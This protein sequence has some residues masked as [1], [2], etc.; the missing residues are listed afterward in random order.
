[1]DTNDT[2]YYLES[3]LGQ[4]NFALSLYDLYASGCGEKIKNHSETI[5][6]SVL[7]DVLEYCAN[8]DVKIV[9][10]DDI[11]I[12]YFI[13][14]QASRLENDNMYLKIAVEIMNTITEHSTGKGICQQMLNKIY[15]N[16]EKNRW[17]DEYGNNGIYTLFKSAIRTYSK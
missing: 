12:I 1:M 8:N 10:F 13:G 5:F 14:K 11:K 3:Y 17:H 4:F 6:A 7:T 9:E 15:N 2:I 16:I